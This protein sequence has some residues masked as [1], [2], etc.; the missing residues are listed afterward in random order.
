MHF[1]VSG[2]CLICFALF[3]CIGFINIKSYSKD[4]AYP[5]QSNSI[6][7]HDLHQANR[8]QGYTSITETQH[9]EYTV[10]MHACMSNKIGL[11]LLL[12]IIVEAGQVDDKMCRSLY[13]ICHYSLRS[14]ASYS[15]T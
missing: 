8:D 10:S 2:V 11:L 9:K 6:Q 13:T 12:K 1:P 15:V 14:L 7:H 4:D 5:I 3:R